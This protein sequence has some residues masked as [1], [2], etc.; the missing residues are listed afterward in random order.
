MFEFKNEN[1]N[2]LVIDKDYVMYY[3][4]CTDNVFDDG[5]PMT[6]IEEIPTCYV[7]DFDELVLF[8]KAIED[9]IDDTHELSNV[10]L[11]AKDEII[12][13][14]N[15]EKIV[16]SRIDNLVIIEVDSSNDDEQFPGYDSTVINNFSG[17]G[18]WSEWDDFNFDYENEEWKFNESRTFFW[19]FQWVEAPTRESLIKA[20]NEYHTLY[21]NNSFFI[22]EEEISYDDVIDMIAESLYVIQW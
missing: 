19:K 8:V 13:Y 22:N 11:S 9:M 2:L 12:N 17:R 20:L 3:Y 18:I 5:L 1:G 14:I 16:H 21:E 6:I 10:V 4:G 15:S 7:G